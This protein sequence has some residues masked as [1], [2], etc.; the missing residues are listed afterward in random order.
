M[1]P[2]R[3]SSYTPCARNSKN[4][5]WVLCF[6]CRERIVRN[7]SSLVL[8]E[9]LHVPSLS[10]K[11][12]SISKITGDYKHDGG[13]YLLHPNSDFDWQD[14]TIYFSSIFC[15]LF[16]D[17]LLWHYSLGY[18]SFHYLK[19][20]FPHYFLTKFVLY[21][22]ASFANLPSIYPFLILTPTKSRNYLI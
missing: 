12:L 21:F 18:H 11:L 7:S 2:A 16:Q 5:G 22:S 9:I 17:I 15:F 10:Y 14:R 1:V 6:C 19:N 8:K 3:L 4:C 13:L 20:M